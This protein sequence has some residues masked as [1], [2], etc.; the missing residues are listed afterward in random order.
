MGALTGVKVIEFG[1]G[2]HGPYAAMLLADM[3]ADVI[4]VEPPTGDINRAAAVVDGPYT[5]SSQ[6]YAC[7]RNKR[8]VCLNLKDPSGQE[9]ARRLV[10]EAD[11]LVENMRTGVLDRFGLGYET[12][13]QDHPKLIYAS[14]S[15]YGPKGPRAG[16]A[17]LDIV[18]QA[19]GGLAAH[20]GSAETGPMPAGTAVADHA[21]AVWLALGVMF[22]LYS[23]EKTG[24]GQRVQSSLLG[25]M[26][27]IQAWELTHYLLSKVEP[28]PG[29]KGHGL[30]GGIWGIF[31]AK[32]GSLAL[33][34]AT[35]TRFP[36]L[37][38]AIGRVDLLSDERFATTEARIE[39][40]ED[41]VAT[42][43][44][45]LSQWSLEDLIPRL[46]AADQVFSKVMDYRALAID[47][48]TLENGYITSFVSQDHGE[49]PMV[50]FPVALSETPGELRSPPPDIDQHTA[51]VLTELGYDE[52]AIARLY[53]AG[54]VGHPVE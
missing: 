23:R 17:S 53:A 50:G 15:G 2:I 54:A 14:A 37:C 34:W 13:S 8:V 36:A 19:A 47:P 20:T 33:A 51:E 10:G 49:L 25:S 4:K 39:N 11:V 42:L 26:I 5:V 7:N 28:P 35:D 45:I 9:I 16:E 3:G 32:D 41:L 43:N 18:A 46:E 24:R 48:Q 27:G 21:G 44:E 6:F 38:E 22:A 52:S 31:D 40:T 30:A 12:L 29:G 1:Y